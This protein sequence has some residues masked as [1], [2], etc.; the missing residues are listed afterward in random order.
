M[1]NDDLPVGRLLTRREAL[2]LFA[3]VA[4]ATLVGCRGTDPTTIAPTAAS[5][6]AATAPNAAAGAATVA[7]PTGTPAPTSAA[8][9]S[10]ATAEAVAL[11]P[12]CVVRPEM[13]EGPFF[14]DNKLNRSDIRSDT[15]TGVVSAGIPLMLTFVVSQ[16]AN[17]ACTLLPGATV[18][19][20]HCD[21]EGVYSEFNEG[22]GM[23]FLRGY[24]TTDEAGRANFTTIYPG[25]YPGRSVHI[26]FKIRLP[27]GNNT[28]DFTSQL[29]FDDTFTDVV[30]QQQ[31]YN[32]RPNRST[33]NS[34]D[35]IYGAGG[36]QLTLGVSQQGD[37]YIAAFDIALDLT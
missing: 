30:Y 2:K 3:G 7:V 11:A 6:G 16:I 25:W 34:S 24:Q 28:Y 15:A 33:L 20:W 29:F 35:G 26:H 21:A 5:S 37:Q 14:A 13:T 36:D 22:A 1:D 17:S 23:D 27:S 8:V 12:S 18:D 32:E 19:I 9:T 10:T 4:V 31:P